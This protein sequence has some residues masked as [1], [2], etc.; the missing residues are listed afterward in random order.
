MPQLPTR[1]PTLLNMPPNRS[2]S[3]LED[4]RRLGG[5]Q[6]LTRH[7]TISN[8]FNR[9]K[10]AGQPS[11]IGHSGKLQRIQGL[12]HISTKIPAPPGP[13]NI[14]QSRLQQGPNP[15]RQPRRNHHTAI[16]ANQRIQPPNIRLHPRLSHHNTKHIF[17][18]Q[19]PGATT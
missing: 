6:D 15:R 13:A 14:T 4:L 3:A 8:Y 10:S 5:S 9:L 19:I 16:R 1:Q 2:F 12:E 17:D 7:I 18:V 11:F